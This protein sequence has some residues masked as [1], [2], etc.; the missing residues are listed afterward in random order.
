MLPPMVTMA[1]RSPSVSWRASKRSL[2]NLVYLGRDFPAPF[3]SSTMLYNGQEG[4]FVA[5]VIHYAA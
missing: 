1:P 4:P 2:K 5:T 3:F